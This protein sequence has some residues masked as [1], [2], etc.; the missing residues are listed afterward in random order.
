VSTTF[1]SAW[2]SPPIFRR[3]IIVAAIVGTA[4]LAIN[5]GDLILAGQWPPY[6]KIILTYL[7]PYLVSSGSATLHAA[8]KD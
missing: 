8:G 2:L 6:W 1:V 3:A 7:V 4:L 5:Q